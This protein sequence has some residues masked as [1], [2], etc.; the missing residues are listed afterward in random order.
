M[1]LSFVIGSNYSP[2]CN[3]RLVIATDQRDALGRKGFLHHQPHLRLL[4][5]LLRLLVPK[6]NWHHVQI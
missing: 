5:R 3:N 2:G 6:D 4:C 1:S